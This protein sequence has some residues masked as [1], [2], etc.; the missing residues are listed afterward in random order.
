M[1][2]S[3]AAWKFSIYFMYAKLIKTQF[4]C[5]FRR[6]FKYIWLRNPMP[7]YYKAFPILLF[8]HLSTLILNKSKAIFFSSS[9][10]PARLIT[11]NNYTYLYISSEW[12]PIL[13]KISK[14]PHSPFR[15]SCLWRRWNIYHVCTTWASP[16]SL[17]SSPQDIYSQKCCYPLL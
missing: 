1:N 8:S 16:V 3:F 13:Y 6:N 5:D 11:I 15:L 10:H 17:I 4:A 7:L 12:Y 9:N 2:W 14:H